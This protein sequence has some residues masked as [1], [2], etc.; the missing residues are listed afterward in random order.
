[1]AYREVTMVEVKEVL[2]QW[3]MKV[4]KKRIA[5]RTGTNPKTVRRYV[6]A[7]EHAGLKPEDGP[8]VLTDEVLAKVLER[9]RGERE[10]GHGE[11]WGRCEEQ[12]GFIQEVLKNRVRLARTSGTRPSPTP[13]APRRRSTASRARRTTWSS[14]G[15]RTGAGR[16]PAGQ[17]GASLLAVLAPAGG[18]RTT[19]L[20]DRKRSGK[21]RTGGHDVLGTR[22]ESS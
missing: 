17:Q 10:R 8:A 12:K 5:R 22:G 14:R 7:G 3:L 20:L 13:S 19:T 2:R 18:R 4:P 21:A 15:S 11:G 9:L 1:M 16:S 6:R